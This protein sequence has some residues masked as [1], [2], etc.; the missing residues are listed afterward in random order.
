MRI[1]KIAQ[2]Q[3][4]NEI[5]QV[6]GY[7][8]YIAQYRENR[9]KGMYPQGILGIPSMERKWD[10]GDFGIGKTMRE[11]RSDDLKS[12]LETL[13]R[14]S[15]NPRTDNVDFYIVEN[16]NRTRRRMQLTEVLNKVR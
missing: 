7:P 10:K 3:E 8:Y 2:E 6:P 14:K 1:Y 12:L 11:I 4:N 16:P 5:P 9:F 13:R 15:I